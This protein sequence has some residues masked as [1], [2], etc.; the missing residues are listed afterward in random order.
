MELDF[1]WKWAEHLKSESEV[2]KIFS[3]RRK[4]HVWYKLESSEWLQQKYVIKYGLHR[5]VL[6][7]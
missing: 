3:A 5:A 1:S 2:S 7:V 6:Q 4:M